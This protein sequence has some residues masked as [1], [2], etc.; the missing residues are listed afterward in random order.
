[1]AVLTLSRTYG[2][3][4]RELARE[5]AQRLDYNLFEKEIVPLLSKKLH[6][7]KEYTLEHDELKDMLS[8]SVIDFASSRFAFLKKDSISPK[9]Y[10][11]A[12]KEIF[13]ELVRN[14]NII[15]VGRGSQF[16]L[17]DHPG[18]FHIRLVANI[19]DRAE[20]LQKYHYIDLQDKI[21]FQKIRK[22]DN[23]RQEFL[24]IH[25]HENGENPL[26]YHL[27]INLSKVSRD[28]AKE[29]ILQIIS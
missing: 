17:Q 14:G 16:I 25:F 29:M 6:R 2:C 27:T 11:K 3:G 18:V 7:K 12:L 13:F 4:V 23:R 1:M 28:K 19:E 8:S 20:H 9:E 5:L 21:L 10:V 22:E 24:K 26:L 15:V